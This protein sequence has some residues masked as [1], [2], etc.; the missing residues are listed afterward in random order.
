MIPV[1]GLSSPERMPTCFLVNLR[2]TPEAQS[3]WEALPE[4][5]RSRILVWVDC[6]HFLDEGSTTPHKV[7]WFVDRCTDRDWRSDWPVHDIVIAHLC[8]AC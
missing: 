4:Q 8:V 6:L 2:R 7:V 3:L 5:L 1:S